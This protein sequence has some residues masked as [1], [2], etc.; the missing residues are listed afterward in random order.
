MPDTV[1]LESHEPT[2]LRGITKRAIAC[3]HHRF[4]DLYRCIDSELLHSSW[5]DLNKRSASGVDEVT[6]EAY[7]KNLDDNIQDLVERLKTKRYRTKLVR[8]CYIPKENGKE[9]PLGL[10]ALEDK[11]V[12]QA[13]AKL[14]NA[15]YEPLFLPNSYGYRKGI[16]AKDAVMD[17]CFNLQYGRF[18]YVVEADI[19]GFFDHLDH[20]WL[21]KM[22]ALKIDDNAL[23]MLIRKWLKGKRL[24]NHTLHSP[25]LTL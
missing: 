12:Q 6:A 18:G 17:L 22:L 2:S 8:R 16:G 11:L 14:L 15:I 10:P 20:D 13:C 4:R 7:G 9:R 24:T 23:L 5:R 21:L 19:K 1:G 25:L 3:K